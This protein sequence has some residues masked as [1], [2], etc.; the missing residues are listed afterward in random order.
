MRHGTSQAVS[1][2]QRPT[3]PTESEE[4]ANSDERMRA[5]SDM[6]SGSPDLGLVAVREGFSS[7]VA[8]D[9]RGRS[10]T[11]PR[12]WAVLCLCACLRGMQWPRARHPLG[13]S[14]QAALDVKS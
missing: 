2:Q 12:S 7:L 11:G 1:D 8:L 13:L 14:P 5:R 3:N 9:W 6:R 4:Q 10:V